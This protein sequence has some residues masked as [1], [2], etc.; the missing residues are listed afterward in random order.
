VA[1]LR[2]LPILV[3]YFGLFGGT[4]AHAG[5]PKPSAMQHFFIIKQLLPK[6]EKV[7]I[8]IPRGMKNKD[9]LLKTINRAA[10]ATGQKAYVA[11]VESLTD[12]AAQFQTLVE[13]YRIKAIWIPEAQEGLVDPVARDYLIQK[14]VLYGVALL[15]PEIQWVKRGACFMLLKGT[16]GVQLFANPKTLQALGMSIPDS[17]QGKTQF[18][19]N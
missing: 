3:I 18:A 10:A 19:V 14:S 8:L 1:I 17:F 15:A 7:G 13:E 5:G 6:A 16:S 2:A 9:H 12:I 11:E 4:F